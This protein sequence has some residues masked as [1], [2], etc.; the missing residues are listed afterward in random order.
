M[1][2]ILNIEYF[3]T[4]EI[5]KKYNEKNFLGTFQQYNHLNT[6]MLKMFLTFSPLN[7]LQDI[8]KSN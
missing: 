5:L 3:Q 2:Q 7:I 4:Y 1:L 8:L 6:V